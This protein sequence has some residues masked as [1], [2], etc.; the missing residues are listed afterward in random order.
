MVEVYVYNQLELH[1]H[2]AIYLI[3]VSDNNCQ[4]K[5]L[6]RGTIAAFS[7][8]KVFKVEFR[9]KDLNYEKRNQNVYSSIEYN[10][11]IHF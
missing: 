9:N 7:N 4:S 2:L 6:F 1:S 10:S 11:T 3:L 8:L 5:Y